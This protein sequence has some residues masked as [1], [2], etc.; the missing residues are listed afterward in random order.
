MTNGC[1]TLFPLLLSVPEPIATQTRPSSGC[2]V[3]PSFLSRAGHVRVKQSCKPRELQLLSCSLLEVEECGRE[4]KEQKGCFYNSHPLLCQPYLVNSLLKRNP[5]GFHIRL[6]YVAVTWSNL[7][8]QHTPVCSQVSWHA[9]VVDNNISEKKAWYRKR[10]SAS[11]AGFKHYW[12][13][14]VDPAMHSSELLSGSSRNAATQGQRH[15]NGK[16]RSWKIFLPFWKS[17]NSKP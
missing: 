8:S 17:F 4:D 2:S 1:K 11:L 12:I 15:R 3:T 6:L 9:A 10:E 7:A 16:Y 14:L 5:R 13:C